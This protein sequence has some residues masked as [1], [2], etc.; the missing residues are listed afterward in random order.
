MILRKLVTGATLADHDDA[1]LGLALQDRLDD[2]AVAME[3]L[4]SNG[5]GRLQPLFASRKQYATAFDLKAGI[6]C[7]ELGQFLEQL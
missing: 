7:L 2:T 6:G 1:R 4:H 5:P 3:R